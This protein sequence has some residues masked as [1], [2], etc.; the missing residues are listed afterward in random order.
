MLWTRVDP[1]AR[2]VIAFTLASGFKPDG[3]HVYAGSQWN[4]YSR[5]F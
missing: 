4:I 1:D 5:R 3:A 2:H